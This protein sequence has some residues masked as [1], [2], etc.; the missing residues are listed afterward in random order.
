MPLRTYV[1]LE[2]LEDRSTPAAVLASHTPAGPA[3]NAASGDPGVSA[4][5][6]F[7]A[8]TSDASD[9]VPGDANGV[10][11]VF[12]MDRTTGAVTQVSRTPAGATGNGASGYNGLTTEVPAVSA[13]G[14]YVA[15]TSWASDLV[16]NDTNGLPDVFLFDRVSGSVSLVSHTPGGQSGSNGSARPSISADG[17]FVAFDSYAGDLTPGDSNGIGDVFLFDRQ[18]GSVRLASHTPAGLAGGGLSL[19]PKISADG[20]TVVF[21][22]SADLGRL[23]GVRDN[24]LYL[25]DRATG[26]VVLV[27]ALPSPIP[28]TAYTYRTSGSPA[29]SGDGRFVAFTSGVYTAIGRVPPPATSDVYLFDRTTGDVTPVTTNPPV[30]FTSARSFTPAISADGRFVAFTTRAADTGVSEVFVYDRAAGTTALVSRTPDGQPAGRNSIAP[31][32]S[33]D[34][35]FVAFTSDAPNLAAGD[36]NAASD[37]FRFDRLTGRNVLVSRTPAGGSAAGASFAPAVSADGQVVV[38]GSVA[39]DLAPLD[40][41]GV[42][43]VFVRTLSAGGLVAVG[44]G[45][46]G[47]PH[48]K[49]YDPAGGV[50]F[51]FLAYDPAFGGGVSVATGDVT[52][53][54]VADIVTAALAGGGPHVKVFDGVTGAEVRSFLAYAP[55]FAGGVSVGVADLDGDGFADIVTGAGAGGGPHVKV[56]SG[57]TGAEVRSFFAYDPAFAGGVNVAA[58]GGRIVTGAGAGGGPHVKVFDWSSGQVV[59][60]FLAFGDAFGGGVSVAAGDLTGDGVPN[61]VAA[62][63]AGGGPHVRV[64]DGATGTPAASFY[65][66][67]PAF[68]G[69]VSVAASDMDGDGVAELLTGA[70]PGGTPHVRAWRLAGDTATPFGGALGSFTAFDTAFHGGVD[71]G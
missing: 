33:E 45:P 66:Y 35:R 4:D 38:F 16:S 46:G 14:R 19:E 25:Y 65:A 40:G 7:V 31:V 18:D 44:A 22:S 69:G 52:G 3:G 61:V 24:D 34:G 51:S 63:G 41:N 2:P 58:A 29:V 54:G 47:S 26:S 43:D 57:K 13:D 1:V 55:G 32:L 5:G 42:T 50:V 30:A 71:V 6:R 53:D 12:L 59:H 37:V 8:F 70:G 36:G 21:R 9:L 60:S 48:V 23:P 56:F 68:G 39:G 17:R 10:K 62:A 11:D 15:F 67:D 28:T 49:G 27:S 64:F 20:S